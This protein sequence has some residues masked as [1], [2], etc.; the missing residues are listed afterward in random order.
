MGNQVE[1]MEDEN[2]LDLDA[3][4]FIIPAHEEVKNNIGGDFQAN[5][6]VEPISPRAEEGEGEDEENGNQEVNQ[7]DAALAAA[8]VGLARK[9][10]KSKKKS[11]SKRGLVF[12]NSI[13]PM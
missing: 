9:K 4:E 7:H 3:A 6:A 5:L 11:K 10:K 1:E 13:V 12:S 2:R 8:G